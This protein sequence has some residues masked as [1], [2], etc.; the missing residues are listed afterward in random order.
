MKEFKKIFIK[1]D[2]Y[3]L[4]ELLA[5]IIVL[6]TVGLVIGA[7]I[8]S[9][10]RGTAKTNIV[11]E[12][13]QEGNNRL[14]ELSKMVEFSQSFDGVSINGIDYNTNCIAEDPNNPTQY[15]YLKMTDFT[16]AELILSCAI[17]PD[18]NNPTIA[19]NGA[20]LITSDSI[21][22]TDCYFTC[23][24]DYL[25]EPPIIGLYFDLMKIVGTGVSNQNYSASFETNI[26][27]RNLG[28]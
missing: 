20:S 21:L 24:Q 22:V 6:A 8:I 27:M 23:T 5:V 18:T 7:I 12:L 26:V 28:K 19:S 9:A 11:G 10:F 17:D 25:A 14:S 15:K 13:R 16:N 1:S 4:I 3:T 2:G